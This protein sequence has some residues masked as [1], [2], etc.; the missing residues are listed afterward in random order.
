MDNTIASGLEKTLNRIEETAK[1]Y[2]RSPEDIQLVAVSKTQPADKLRSAYNLG[3]KHFG[4][5]YLQEAIEKITALSDCDITWHFIGSIQS[6][7]AKIIA[8]KFDWVHSID[9]LKIAQ[10]LNDARP[11]AQPPLNVCLQVNI[12]AEDTKSG[13]ESGNIRELA[14]QV[15]NLPKLKLRGLMALPAACH[16]FD[17]QRANFASL[18]QSLEI[19][20]QIDLN[21]DTLSM[22]MSNDLEAA[23]AEGATL[24]RVGSAIFGPRL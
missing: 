22:G 17:Q 20:K 21:L 6:N 12:S 13:I 14:Q 5:N 9:R 16:D 15:A 2:G 23:I 4:E 19:L 18:R 1:R 24:V 7:K 11:D 10:R 3:Q 8:E